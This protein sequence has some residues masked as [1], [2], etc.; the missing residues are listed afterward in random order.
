[1]QD[2]YQT[3]EFYKILEAISEYSKTELGKD[4]IANLSMYSSSKQVKESLDDLSEMISIILRFG[5]LPINNSANAIKL[6]EMGKKT[7][8]LTPRDLNLLANDVLTLQEVNN[9]LKQVDVSYPRIK[10]KVSGYFDLSSLQKE[11]NRVITNAL[12]VDD[13]ATAKL[14]EIRTKLKKLEASLNS[15]ATS[16]AFSY[17][18][19]LSGDNITIRDGH[20]VLPV[21][22]VD[23]N[24]VTGVIYG[25]SDSGNTTFIEP[26][27]IVS[28]NNEI[29]ALKVEENEEVRRILKQLTSLVLLQEHEILTNNRIISELDFLCAKAN[30]ASSI[31]AEIAQISD[32]QIVDL[33]NARHPLIEPTKVVA[34]SYYIDENKRIVI[35]SGPNAGGKTVSLKTIGLLVLMNQCGLAIPVSKAELGFFKNIFIDIG[36]N[37]SLSDNLSTFSAHMSHIEQISNAVGGKDLVLIDELGTGTDPKEGEAI[38]LGV[39]NYLVNKHCLAMISSHFQALKELALSHPNVENSSMLF[40][41][42]NLVP[43]YRFKSGTPG[44]SYGVSVAKRYGIKPEIIQIA[45]EYLKD[46]YNNDTD[47][48]ISTLQKKIEQAS[49]LEAELAKEKAR[50]EKENARL[51]NLNK[52]LTEKHDHLLESVK[53]E[54]EDMLTKAK[55]EIDTIIHALTNSDLKL[56]EVIELKKKLLSLEEDESEKEIF[57]EEIHVGDYVS[58]PSLDITGRVIEIRG[59][60]ARINNESGIS[61]Q[62]SLNRLHKVNNPNKTSVNKV[63]KPVE[64]NFKSVPIELNIIGLHVD[65]A[66]DKLKLYID[67]CRMKH[68]SK[69]RII[70][71]FGSGALRK[72]T[73]NYLSTQKDLT[74]RLGDEYEGGGGATVVIFK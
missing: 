17:A 7:G 41:E 6:I 58:I 56:H 29:T 47:I 59:S 28:M 23:K 27:E 35:I 5:P 37:Q 67:D 55:S 63:S 10:N 24:K 53:Q 69:V 62:V 39:V 72:M 60:N 51:V 18:Q 15:K 8:L 3:F 40:D 61:L 65:E 2:I 20:Y 64:L 13:K 12:T 46:N 71:G 49:L 25:I 44:K 45:E 38:A 32:A 36:D 19:Y 52:T 66:S 16:I 22:T 42:N 14:F 50:L 43:T 34:N 31:N 4:Y 30:Y 1:M 73:H 9:Y 26:L 48:L 21:K 68:M 33:T 11:I 74:Y 70:H 57:D 54:K